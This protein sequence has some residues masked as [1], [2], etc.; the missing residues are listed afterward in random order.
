METP[1]YD[2]AKENVYKLVPR[3]LRFHWPE[4]YKYLME[5]YSFANKFSE[6]LYCYYNNLIAP[7]KCYCGKPVK[8]INFTKGYNQ[9]C[10]TKCA[11]GSSQV[12]EGRK[13]TCRKKYG[14]DACTSSSDVRKKIKDTC[15]KKYGGDAPTCSAEVREKVR[16]TCQERYG[17]SYI[18]QIP[19]FRNRAVKTCL[20]R[21]GTTNPN[22]LPEIQE[23]IKQTCLERYG[24]TNPNELPEIQERIKQTCLERYGV[25]NYAQ[26]E[27]FTRTILNQTQIKYPDVIGYDDSGNWICKCPHPECTKCQE[28]T[29]TIPAM[30]HYSRSLAGLNI[31]TKI[32]PVGTTIKD[33]TIELFIKHILD[34]YNIQYQQNVRGIIGRLELD[35]YIPSHNLAI[36]CN[37]VYWHSE[38][39]K[40]KH[41][42]TKK[43]KLC[44]EQGI[45]LLYFWEDQIIS[46]PDAVRSVLLSKLG[47]YDRTIGAR[48]CNIKL[49]DCNE[50]TN[51]L[52]Y[53]LQGPAPAKRT[54][55][56]YY[57]DELLA[58]MSFSKRNI[59]KLSD[60]EII[61][62]C[63]IPGTR[64]QGGANKL[65]SRFIKNTNPGKIISYSSNDISNGE[66]YSALGFTKVRETDSYWYIDK[67][68][69]RH[70]RYSFRKSNLIKNGADPTKS[71]AQITAEMGLLRIWDAGQT[72]WELTL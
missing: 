61:R 35:F 52:K 29:Y 37:G 28:R 42:H 41:Y 70:H 45:N 22:E 7:S 53:H 58:V 69:N 48:K 25:E 33:T 6:K 36:E 55:G 3:V 12:K 27:H 11:A 8:F 57:Q 63:C 64:V 54:Y 56:L 39:C 19:E 32:N 68:M 4:F 30:V 2:W 31:C 71:E 38:Y 50:A 1:T 24:T 44:T 46:N 59:N 47:I 51:L 67:Q 17:V 26:S 20:E 62:Y 14:G 65:L 5:N 21:Y 23:R 9:F 18:S 10:S 66:L 13:A 72:R 34:E 43:K 49:I 40:P 15:R 60:W 16:A